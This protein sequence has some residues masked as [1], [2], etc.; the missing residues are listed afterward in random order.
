MVVIVT[1]VTVL[2]QPKR[3]SLGAAAIYRSITPPPLNAKIPG[4][5][6]CHRHGVSA[7]THDTRTRSHNVPTCE[8]VDVVCW[9]VT[10]V[11]T[12]FYDVICTR[13]KYNMSY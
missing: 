11:N 10:Y 4:P 5:V 3:T 9:N 13:I 7:C 12:P 2:A 8:W 6:E 1:M